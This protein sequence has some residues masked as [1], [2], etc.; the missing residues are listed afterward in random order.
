[1]QIIAYTLLNHF[2]YNEG[3]KKFEHMHKKLINIMQ[4]W[5]VKIYIIKKTVAFNC[6]EYLQENIAENVANQKYKKKIY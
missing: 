4:N 1:M 3:K 5:V 2:E 6:C